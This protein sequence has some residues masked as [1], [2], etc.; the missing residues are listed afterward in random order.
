MADLKETLKKA[1]ALRDDSRKPAVD[2]DGVVQ[3][4][5]PAIRKGVDTMSSRPFTMINALGLMCGQR[6]KTTAPLEYDLMGR[7]RKALVDTNQQVQGAG[8]GSMMYPI[9]R[10]FLAPDIANHE[11]TKEL[12]QA[13]GAG[14]VGLD[15]EEMVHYAK[16][17]APQYQKSAMSYLTDTT[18]GTLVA[19]PEMGEL[20][21][22][23]R[24]HSCLDRAGA[25][26]VPLPPQGKWVAP[27]VTGPSTGYWIGENTQITESNPTTGEVSMMAKKLAV[28]IRVP[29]ELFKYASTAADAL[30]RDDVAKTLALGQDYAG[31]YGAGS[32]GQP[33]G[34]INFT[35]TNELLDY[36]AG[37]PAPKGVATNGNTL[38]PED[39]YAMSSIIEDRN[40]DLDDGWKWIMRPRM[41]GTIGGYRGDAVTAGD[42]AGPFAQAITRLIGAN[43]GKEWCGYEVVR[44]AQVS[45][46][47][48]KG[49]GTGLTQLWGGV[50][51]KLLMGMYGAVEFATNNLGE[52][53]FYQDQT[54]IRGILHCD[55]V[56]CY[57]GAFAYYKALLIA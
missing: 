48:T 7:F 41:W 52:A 44:S 55:S 24:N 11:V 8:S 46:S 43:L 45:A 29:N 30:L 9:S 42:A 21:P 53:T 28:L 1:K 37:T 18:G 33:K 47:G 12:T 23:M 39:G 14:T 54:M 5:V 15:P 13:I 3:N 20:I 32:G 27:R 2:A 6:D 56:P 34:L 26:Q 4:N 19:P 10:S 36:A 40:F 25:K 51:N 31:L 35:G 17:Y 38:R 22:L 50:W 49:S 16:N 57:P